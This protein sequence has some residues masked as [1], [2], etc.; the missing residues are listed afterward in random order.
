MADYGL[1]IWDANGNQI[2]NPNNTICR[3]VHTH[4]AAGS[5]TGSVTLYGLGGKEAFFM[6]ALK[7]YGIFDTTNTYPLKVTLQ[8]SGANLILSWEAPGADTIIY[9]FVYI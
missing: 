4:E 8:P 2:F 1:A 3:L 7:F 5:T 6:S 9:V